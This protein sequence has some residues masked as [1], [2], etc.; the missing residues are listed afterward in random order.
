MTEAP[1]VQQVVILPAGGKLRLA[2][3]P[4]CTA[5]DAQI[6]SAGAEGACPAASRVGTGGADG[7]LNGV[8]VHFDIGIYAVRGHLVLAAEQGGK[9]LK[10]SFNG[11]AK[12]RRL[13]LTVPTLGGR[14]YPTEFDAQIGPKPG[15]HAWLQTPARCPASGHWVVVGKFRGLTS[16]TSHGHRVGPTQTKTAQDACRTA[17]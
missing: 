17:H 3:L 15:G 10:Q 14:I 12:G 13:V 6:A 11:F 4:Q 5:T 1:A 8:P 9:P 16:T 2:K 7:L